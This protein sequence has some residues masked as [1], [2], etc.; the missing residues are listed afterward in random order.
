M[1]EL[2][3]VLINNFHLFC[4]YFLHKYVSE[5]NLYTCGDEEI[6]SEYIPCFVGCTNFQ[7]FYKHR[8]LFF[9]GK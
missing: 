2:R 5:T 8:C 6:H 7:L 3:E 1:R 9:G 4:F